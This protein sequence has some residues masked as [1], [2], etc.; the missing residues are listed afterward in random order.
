MRVHIIP[1]D[2]HCQTTEYGVMTSNGRIVDRGCCATAIPALREVIEAVPRPRHVVFEEGPLAD[3]LWRNLQGVAD[4]VIVSE[5]RRNRLIAQEGE[6][7]DPIDVAKLG[8][9]YRGG[10]IRPVHHSDSQDRMLFK[11]CVSIYAGRVR[12]STRLGHEII[13][14]L[15]RHGVIIP[16]K[17]F[18]DEADRRAAMARLPQHK[19]LHRAIRFL[20]MEHNLVRQHVAQM[21]SELVRLARN[22]E[23][24]RRF[25]EVPGVK[26]VRAAFFFAYV[27]TPWRFKT[28]SKLWKYM[29]IGLERR[30]S[31]QSLNKLRVV[32]PNRACRPLKGMIL[33]AAKSAIRGENNPFA[34]EYERLREKGVTPRNARRSVAR[35]MASTL[36][37][38]WKNGS[39]YRPEDVGRPCGEPV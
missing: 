35:S 5:P 33:M 39:A 3:W 21:R 29:G 31:G 14:E 2:T 34:E 7:D 11:Q 4:Q 15:R 37:G 18:Q 9:L 24:I 28:R 19:G 26:W 27:D 36:W 32:R 22:H 17:C 16:I 13:W 23:P 12:Q 30:K 1:L 8:D 25:V 38:M 6:K 10:Y 20:C